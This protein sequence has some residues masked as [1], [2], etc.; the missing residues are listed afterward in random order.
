MIVKLFFF[1]KLQYPIVL[2]I[3]TTIKSKKVVHVS[4]T[5][6]EK[7][8]KKMLKPRVQMESKKETYESS[9]GPS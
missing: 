3:E 5:E 7:K 2:E 8:K 6:T 1:R 9:F 4:E